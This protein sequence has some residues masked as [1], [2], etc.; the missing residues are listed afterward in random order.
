MCRPQKDRRTNT[1]GCVYRG[2]DKVSQADLGDSSGLSDVSAHTSLSTSQVRMTSAA[3]FRFLLSE[4]NSAIR[5]ISSIL[6]SQS[7]ASCVTLVYGGSSQ[8]WVSVVTF[9]NLTDMF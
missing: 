1:C 2:G 5:L 4:F 8:S 9:T 3:Q 7:S 6:A